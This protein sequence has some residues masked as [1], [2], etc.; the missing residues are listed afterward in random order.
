MNPPPAN[1][2]GRGIRLEAV[3]ISNL[4]KEKNE[5]AHL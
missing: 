2:G 3:V 4:K 5:P 1:G